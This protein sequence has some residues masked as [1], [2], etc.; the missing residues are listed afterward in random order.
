MADPLY[1]PSGKPTQGAPGASKDVRDEFALIEAGIDALNL[2]PI[3][4]PFADFNTAGSLYVA[5]PWS[6]LFVKAVAINLAANGTADTT[7]TFEIGG[8]AVTM[9]A[10]GNIVFAAADNA[11]QLKNA[12]PAS[13]NALVTDGALEIVTDGGGS[14]SMPG[15]V[16]MFFQRT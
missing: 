2:Y 5:V 10:N 3:S 8:T 14:T 13:G 6:C 15:T 9:D 4:I 1:T 16:S 7:I 11:N 12:V